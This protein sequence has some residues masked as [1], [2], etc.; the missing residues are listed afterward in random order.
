MTL[1]DYMV[2][3]K[4]IGETKREK[5]KRIAT[6]RTLRILNDIRLLGNCSNVGAY[7][8]SDED[9][10]KILSTIEKELKRIRIQFDKPKRDFSL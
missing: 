9:V 3:L 2:K 7:T 10:T 6:S 1:V 8:Y 5:F 4:V